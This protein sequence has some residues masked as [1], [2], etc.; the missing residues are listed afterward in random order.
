MHDAYNLTVAQLTLIML[1]VLLLSAA[2]A[3]AWPH[4]GTM[5]HVCAIYFAVPQHALQQHM[6]RSATALLAEQ[7]N[8]TVEKL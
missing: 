7:S 5:R 4:C 3:A 8:C 2:Y 1:R 6:K